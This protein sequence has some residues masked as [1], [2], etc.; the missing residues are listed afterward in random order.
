MNR[1]L[2][3]TNYFEMIEVKNHKKKRSYRIRL[4]QFLGYDDLVQLQE[5]MGDYISSG[6]STWRFR[7]KKDADRTLTMLLLYW[8]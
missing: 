2:H 6:R 7:S 1:V 8:N 5:L 3:K 4:C